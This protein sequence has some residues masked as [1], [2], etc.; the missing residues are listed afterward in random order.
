MEESK[1]V[2]IEVFNLSTFQLFGFLQEIFDMLWHKTVSKKDFSFWNKTEFCVYWYIR[3]IW[4]TAESM[5]KVEL[6]DWKIEELKYSILQFCNFSILII[7]ERRLGH[8]V[9]ALALGGDEG[10]DKLR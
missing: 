7:G 2:R 3:W 6:K 8:L 10:R 1:D 9:D 5:S 4:I